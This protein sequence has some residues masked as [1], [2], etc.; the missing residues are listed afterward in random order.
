MASFED[1][2][3]DLD[4]QESIETITDEEHD[5]HDTEDEHHTEDEDKGDD[6][7]KKEDHSGAGGYATAAGAIGA[8]LGI[9]MGGNKIKQKRMERAAAKKK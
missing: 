3:D 5:D 2:H 6:N 4:H 1:D 8:T 9:T 7:D